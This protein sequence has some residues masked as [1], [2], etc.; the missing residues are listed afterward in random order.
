MRGKDMSKTGD[1][2][3]MMRL[4]YEQAADDY[5]SKKSDSMVGSY[6]KYY[7]KNVGMTC[8]D[9]QRD[10]MMFWNE[11]NSQECPI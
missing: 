1:L 3:L 4:S 10:I 6:K 9:P 5:N 11:D 8:Y 7:K 2:Y